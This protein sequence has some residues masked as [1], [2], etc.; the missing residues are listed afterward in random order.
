MLDIISTVPNTDNVQ[1]GNNEILNLLSIKTYIDN[2]L[3]DI[4]ISHW[5]NEMPKE[6][7]LEYIVGICTGYRKYYDNGYIRNTNEQISSPFFMMKLIT[8]YESHLEVWHKKPSLSQLLYVVMDSFKSKTDINSIFDNTSIYANR[9][10][11]IYDVI[12]T[13]KKYKDL[14][15]LN[16]NYIEDSKDLYIYKL[17]NLVSSY[18]D[19]YHILKKYLH[20]TDVDSIDFKINTCTITIHRDYPP[21]DFIL[22]SSYVPNNSAQVAETLIYKNK[23]FYI[24]DITNNDGIIEYK[25]NKK[26]T[27]SYV[28]YRNIVLEELKVYNKQIK[29]L[30]DKHIMDIESLNKIEIKTLDDLLDV[31]RTIDIK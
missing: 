6:I 22:G 7:D 9:D 4:N 21:T 29:E 17:K 18:I 19:R 30:Y 31:M 1:G 3:G 15:I 16:R 20:L 25:T 24:S 26:D 11:N 23:N 10:L 14:S 12:L 8:K 27:L 28:E 5:L 13:F 2:E